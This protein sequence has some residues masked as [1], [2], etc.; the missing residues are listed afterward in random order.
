S[1]ADSAEHGSRCVDGDGRDRYWQDK[2]TLFKN[3]PACVGAGLGLKRRLMSTPECCDMI[4]NGSAG[5][6]HVECAAAIRRDNWSVFSNA[7]RSCGF[8]Q[9]QLA[10]SQLITVLKP[11]Y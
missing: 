9:G 10:L 1:S 6:M 3:D 11:S 7:M 2:A 4:N 8:P 5:G